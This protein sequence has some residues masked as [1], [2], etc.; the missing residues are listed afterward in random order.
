MGLVPSEIPSRRDS[1]QILNYE[2]ED[3]LM[4]FLLPKSYTAG[5]V[6]DFKYIYWH[7]PSTE[8]LTI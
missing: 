7:L 3:S 1:G 6:I 4:G 8:P 2:R 5:F